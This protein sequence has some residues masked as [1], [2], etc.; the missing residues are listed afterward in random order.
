MKQWPCPLVIRQLL[1][2]CALLLA[3]GS[4]SALAAPPTQQD[5]MRSA[6]RE[7]AQAMSRKYVPDELGNT[8]ERQA[9]LNS[10]RDQLSRKLESMGS[11]WLQQDLKTP[12]AGAPAWPQDFPQRMIARW[13]E[14]YAAAIHAMPPETKLA[15]L[16]IFSRLDPN[17]ICAGGTPAVSTDQPLDARLD[18]IALFIK[19]LDQKGQATA[20]PNPPMFERMFGDAWMAAT[21]PAHMPVKLSPALTKFVKALADA[22]KATEDFDIRSC[23]LILW[24]T[25]T[26]PL[27]G[28]PERSEDV[29]AFMHHSLAA[30]TLS[31]GPTMLIHNP[32]KPDRA[33]PD[34]PLVATMFGI[35]G[36]TTVEV[37]LDDAGVPRAAW[38]T[39]RELVVP[40]LEGRQSLAFKHV[41]DQASINNAMGRTYRQTNTDSAKQPK[42]STSIEFVWKLD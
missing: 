1:A 41:F 10:L 2:M 32:D 9:R 36:K 19:H 22:T 17:A 11:V 37:S 30:M 40:G 27:K 3:G 29:D 6:N 13:L 26:V 42:R 5:A 34:Y 16:Q 4:L 31:L 7:F 25:Q 24:W 12:A 21:Y 15:Q 18:E 38:V 33:P 8:P 14:A 23:E 35:T 39:A 28:E 20:A